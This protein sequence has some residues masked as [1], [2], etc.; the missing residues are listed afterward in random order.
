[1]RSLI[2]K[3][4]YERA[5]IKAA[6]RL[7][8]DPAPS[9]WKY[10]YQR[11]MLTPG[12][13]AMVKIG[14]P[15]AIVVL[16]AGVWVAQDDN[17]A[18]IT[19]QY[20]AV[21]SA[22]QQRPEFIV[23]HMV[24]VGADAQTVEDVQV[25]LPLD[26]PVSSFDLDLTEMRDTVKDLYAVKNAHVRVGDG[27]ALVVE[28]TPRVPVAV[29][30]EDDVVRLIDREGEISGILESRA[31]R[32]DLPLIAGDGAYANLEEALVL[33]KTAAPIKE[34]VRALVRM[35]ERRWDFVLDGGQR[36]M[37]P[38]ENPVAALDHMIVLNDAH[39]MLNRDIAAVDMRDTKRAVLR[40]SA[41]AANAYRRTSLSG[42]D[43]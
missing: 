34:R 6:K 36:L 31:A 4:R 22:V 26:F 3:H 29:W 21:K 27:G 41:D 18:M 25:M 9:M 35:G 37:L 7:P 17:R 1:M 30:R 24:V 43:D 13:R 11:W 33:F 8:R 38:A 5:A 16:A 15:V 23:S 28:V 10:R 40:M 12:V 2:R 32:P 19:A 20:E 42:E 39:D 14:T